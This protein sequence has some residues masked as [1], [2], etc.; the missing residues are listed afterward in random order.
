MN[1]NT[2]ELQNFENIYLYKVKVI[3]LAIHYLF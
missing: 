1:E 3:N 2:L